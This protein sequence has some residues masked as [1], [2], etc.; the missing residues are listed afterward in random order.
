MSHLS[1]RLLLLV[2]LLNGSPVLAQAIEP[3]KDL[4]GAQSPEPKANALT[5]SQL[6]ELARARDPRAGQATAQLEG[7]QAKR[8][9]VGLAW[10][11][12]IEVTGA[13][14]GPSAD[15]RL[16]GPNGGDDNQNLF[17]LRTPHGWGTLG[18]AFRAQANAVIPIY[19]F[20]KWAAGKAATEHYVGFNEALLARARDQATFDI[21]RAFWGYQTAHAGTLSID[22]VRKRLTDA[23]K[24]AATLLAEESEQ[25][26]KNDAL[27]L[28]YLR[29]EIEAQYAATV[30]NERLAYN[31][32][33]A[34]IGSE[35]A[36]TPVI[37]Q[38][39]LP[40]A[41]EVPDHDQMLQRAFDHR[42]EAKAAHE[43]VAARQGLV[44][45]ERARLYPD[46]AVVAGATFTYTTNA[47]SPNSPFVYDPYNDRSAY[48]ALAVRGT[49]DFPQKLA[50]VRQAEAD[51]HEAQAL[52][53]GAEQL[54]RFELE[55]A[56]N[57][58]TEAK[59]RV[60]R[61]SKEAAIAKQLALTAGIAFEGGLGEA[62]EL[63]E[64]TL[65]FA[66]AD[67]ERLKALFDAQIGLAS[68]ARAV[69]GL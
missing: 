1:A 46:V 19:S 53:R 56:L 37:E 7:A 65:L 28:D 67:G 9:E 36:A 33:K 39:T 62:R 43:G 54:I 69:G 24:T 29:E 38:R 25:V 4:P 22:A 55:Q 58:L 61:Y 68:L 23:Q 45:L 27:K 41:F 40:A 52:A 8:D 66:R 42:P 13:I 26:S 32:I 63:L 5:L 16:N 31:G 17:D 57:D 30:K 64:D 47:S 49:L 59:V 51:L 12:V 34:L 3:A 15:A 2:A 18:A 35:P 10:F 14:A 21:T 6:I 11:P 44:D 20:G 48:L 50:R 60:D